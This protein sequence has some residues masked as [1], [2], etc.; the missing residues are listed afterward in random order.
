MQKHNHFES[1]R[2]VVLGDR[3]NDFKNSFYEWKVLLPAGMFWK[4]FF[5]GT[6]LVIM[7]VYMCVNC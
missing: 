3:N 2:G 5:G 4:N 6:E 1:K 7:Q